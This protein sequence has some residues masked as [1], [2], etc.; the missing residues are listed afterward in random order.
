[1]SARVARCACGD[2]QATLEG[3]PDFVI[4]CHC[5]EC[6]RRT[7]SAFGVGAYYP[8][9]RVAPAGAYQTYARQGSSGRGLRFHFCRR[10]GGTIF[11]ELDI[12]PQHYGIAVGAL[13]DPAF[14]APLRSVWEE[15]RHPWVGFDCEIGRYP[16]QVT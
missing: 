12:R 10:C 6:Q 15:T 3:E 11:W 16:R 7:G 13:G 9:E 14:R 4:A 2:L 8:R 1:M 5:L